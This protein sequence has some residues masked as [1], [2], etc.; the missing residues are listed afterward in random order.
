MKSVLSIGF[1]NLNIGCLI[2]KAS[3]KNEKSLLEKSAIW[4]RN[5][6]SYL[7]FRRFCHY[8]YTTRT[9]NNYDYIIDFTSS[10]ILSKNKKFQKNL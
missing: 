2:P 1:N 3:K 5:L 10:R 4:K 9:V 6:I 8:H 7:L